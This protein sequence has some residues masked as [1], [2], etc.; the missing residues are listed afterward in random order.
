MSDDPPSG[1]QSRRAF[2]GTIATGSVVGLAGC[3]SRSG[4]P[5]RGTAIHYPAESHPQS[6]AS[7]HPSGPYRRH[8]NDLRWHSLPVTFAVG[9]STYP[10]Y[11]AEDGVTDAIT[12]SFDA[13]NGVAG[14][15]DVFTAP[16]MDDSLDS[17]TFENGVNELV[18]EEMPDDSLGRAHWRWAS[19]TS[20]LLEVDIRMN[21]NR[22]WFVDSATAGG[23]VDAYDVQSV[24]THELGHNA[25]LDVTDAPDQTMFHQTSAGATRKRTLGD[26]DRAG[27][28]VAY[29]STE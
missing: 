8:E 27:W 16:R 21:P 26:G 10:D 7:A 6:H 22:T 23:S 5:G 9:T 20:K 18:W 28:Q 19:G 25:L 14:T 2:L 1:G 15:P 4:D 17:I 11:L 13:W 24:L 3:N 29:G 12:A